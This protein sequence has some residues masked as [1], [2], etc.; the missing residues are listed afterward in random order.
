M[1]IS[2]PNYIDDALNVLHDDIY[3]D[4]DDDIIADYSKFNNIELK[5]HDKLIMRKTLEKF[6]A[7]YVEHEQGRGYPY[8]LK[9]GTRTALSDKGIVNEFFCQM[10]AKN[11]NT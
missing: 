4:I 5:E 7:W 2:N 1:V 6:T 11:K 3:K 10:N 9:N 8:H